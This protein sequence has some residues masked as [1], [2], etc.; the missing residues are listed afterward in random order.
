M[1]ESLAMSATL[2][3]LGGG[4]IG[5]GQTEP[6]DRQIASFS[7]QV[8]P[9][10]L[11]LGTAS[12][13]TPSY[14]DAVEAVYSHYG[15]QCLPLNLYEETPDLEE[16]R[17]G[18]SWAD[19]LYIGGGNTR[20]LLR[21]FHQ[22]GFDNLLLQAIER[23]NDLVVAGL[24]AGASCFCHYSYADCDIM[25][26]KSDKMAWLAGFG[27]FPYLFTP[28]ADGADRAHF[29]DDFKKTG[30]EEALALEDLTALVYEGKSHFVLKADKSKH[31]Y[32]YTN[33]NGIFE[34]TELE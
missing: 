28:H 34:K 21:R 19:I 10:L 3:L 18:L 24:S 22:T 5:Q 32:R 15:C 23:R 9:H 31:A 25:D 14:F 13:D 33:R 29:A 1:V 2:V 20:D 30:E 8:N 11:F 16:L 26:G 12:H 4:E 27:Y 7:R 6:L 17:S